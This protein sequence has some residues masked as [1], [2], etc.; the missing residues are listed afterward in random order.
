M[1]MA[2]RMTDFTIH[3]WADWYIIHAHTERGEAW[4]KNHWRSRTDPP[5]SRVTKVPR[6]LSEIIYWFTNY[7][8]GYTVQ[9]ESEV[10]KDLK[11]GER[12]LPFMEDT[13]DSIDIFLV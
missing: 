1:V 10:A 5:N 7:E 9:V 4:M 13:D 3:K 8:P 12:I 2:E 11:P 6:L